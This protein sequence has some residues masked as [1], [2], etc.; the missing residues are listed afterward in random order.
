M[1]NQSLFEDQ[2]L[3]MEETIPLT[4]DSLLTY[5]GRYKHWFL[6]FSGGKDSTAAVTF[7]AWAIKQDLIPRPASI[8]VQYSDTRMELTPLQVAALKI[9]EELKGRGFAVNVV[10][11]ALDDRFFV[12]MFGRG[13]PP[14]SNT[15]RWCTSQLKIEPMMAAQVERAV[16]QFCPQFAKLKDNQN[17]NQPE[18]G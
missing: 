3:S 17:D 16:S 9:L 8:T 4:L 1:R 13:V 7:I 2:R 14:P 15:F 18:S 11:P 10:M 12:Y 6:A 5:G